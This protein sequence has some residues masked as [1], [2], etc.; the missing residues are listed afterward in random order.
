MAVTS[1]DRAFFTVE[2]GSPFYVQFNPKEVKLDDAAAWKAS[3]E[4]GRGK[5]LITYERGEPAVL[6]FDLIFDS[7]FGGGS[8]V[9]TYIN[10]LRAMT[11]PSVTETVEAEKVDRPPHVSFHWG[12][13]TFDGVVEKISSTSL[14]FDAAGKAVRA[15]VTVTMKERREDAGGK[16]GAGSQVT[17]SSSSAMVQGA[18]ATT[19]TVQPGQTMSQVAA[20]AGVSPRALA[21][22]NPTADVLAPAAG[23]ELVIPG[24]D[25]TAAVLAQ[26][27]RNVVP[28]NFA[29]DDDLSPFAADDGGLTGVLGGLG[30]DDSELS[31]LFSTSGLLGLVD[32]GAEK[33]HEVLE[34][35]EDKVH[36][37]ADKA[38]DGVVKVADKV[39]LGSQAEGL[40]DDA[41][42]AIDQGSDEGH[43]QINKGQEA[44]H[45]AL[46]D[47]D[48][49]ATYEDPDDAPPEG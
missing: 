21:Q 42:G 48:F 36:V 24:D 30:G 12:G 2:G 27:A 38:I 8:A 11:Y 46:G 28:T 5:P 23:T 25:A 32:K 19:T 18:T 44:V 9:Q 15:K 4:H 10:A 3:K 20:A 14:M 37:V 26:Q 43:E 13:F 35:V 17:L 6:T 34:K 29:P 49:E 33:A 22:A 39:G 31:S 41:H 47:D 1:G 16:T 45:S 40:R 7:T